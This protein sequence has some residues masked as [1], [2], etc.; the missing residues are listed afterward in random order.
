[1]ENETSPQ[2]AVPALELCCGHT[3]CIWGSVLRLWLKAWV[4]QCHA[5][6]GGFLLW[7]SQLRAAPLGCASWFG[8]DPEAARVLCAVLFKVKFGEEGEMEGKG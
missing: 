6:S 4:C 7:L 3:G 8:L 5:G 2:P 1:M